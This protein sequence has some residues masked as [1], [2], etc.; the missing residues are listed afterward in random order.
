MGD[1]AVVRAAFD[2]LPGLLGVGRRFEG[3][4]EILDGGGTGGVGTVD[5]FP[6]VARHMEHTKGA[7]ANGERVNGR[8]AGSGKRILFGDD[9]IGL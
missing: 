5:P 3:R 6:N 9:E 7:F 4:L 1:T 8:G 2:V